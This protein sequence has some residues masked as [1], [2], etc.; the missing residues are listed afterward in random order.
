MFVAPK[1]PFVVNDALHKVI[2]EGKH[3]RV[4][5]KTPQD[6]ESELPS[7]L[8]I[9]AGERLANITNDQWDD[10]LKRIEALGG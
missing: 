4:V 1:Y 3:R 7:L 10:V 6:I 2:G 5:N 9:P 8:T